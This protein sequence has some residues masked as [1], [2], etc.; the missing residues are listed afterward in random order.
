MYMCNVCVY[1]CVYVSVC[2]HTYI[3]ISEH[4]FITKL[5]FTDE[6]LSVFR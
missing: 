3:N 2:A 4:K 5:R 1:V 6:S